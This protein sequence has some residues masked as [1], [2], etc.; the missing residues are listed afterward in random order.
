MP[1]VQPNILRAITDAHG[2]LPYDII[3][4]FI[5][6]QTPGTYATLFNTTPK[7]KQRPL[8]AEQVRILY[9]AGDQGFS[10]TTWDPDSVEADHIPGAIASLVVPKNGEWVCVSIRDETTTKLQGQY[11]VIFRGMIRSVHDKITDAGKKYWCEALSDVTRLNSTN[12][13][14][15]ANFL[16]DP[17]N[18]SPRFDNS[19]GLLT[20]ARLKTVYEIAQDIMNFSSAFGTPE[21][22]QFTDIDWG[23]LDTDPRCGGYIPPTLNFSDTPKGK[24]LEDLLA[25]AGNFTFVYVPA[26]N[27]RGTIRIVELNLAC[28]KCGSEWPIDYAPTTAAAQVMFSNYAFQFRLAEDNTE[29]NTR[30]S[31][32][33]VRLTTGDPIRFYSGNYII[34]ELL[35]GD[36]NSNAIQLENDTPAAQL[37]RALNLEFVNYRFTSLFD[38]AQDNRVPKIYPVGLPLFPDWNIHEDH[39]PAFLE[40]QDA[41]LP[42]SGNIVTDGEMPVTMTPSTYRGLVEY[43]TFTVGDEIC[44]GTPRVRYIN[45]LRTYQ[46]WYASESCPACTPD[47]WPDG[48]PGLG[49]VQKV[50]DNDQNEPE[51]QWYFVDGS[52]NK[53][54]AED[55]DIPGTGQRMTYAVTNY[56]WNPSAFGNPDVGP[57]GLVPWNSTAGTNYYNGTDT[58]NSSYPLPWK[59]LCPYCRGTGMKPEF[60][61]RDISADLFRG[62]NNQINQPGGVT[63]IP[64]D[65]DFTQTGPETF[66]E[67]QTRLSI[68]ESAWLAVEVPLLKPQLPIYQ[69]RNNKFKVLRD[70]TPDDQRN[71][72]PNA[73]LYENTTKRLP[74]LMGVDGS[75]PSAQIVPSNWTCE[76]PYTTVQFGVHA[77]V[78]WALGRVIFTEP[79]V[80]PCR[81]QYTDYVKFDAGAYLIASDGTLTPRFTGRG[82]YFADGNW[83]PTGFWRHARVWMQFFFNRS[84]HYE[85]MFTDRDGNPIDDT[86]FSAPTPDGGTGNYK[87]RTSIHDGRLVIEVQKVWPGANEAGG[88]FF[89]TGNAIFQ[90][91]I[92]DPNARVETSLEDLYAMPLPTL[93]N[94]DPATYEAYKRDVEHLDFP[95]AR[96]FKMEATTPG[97][98]QAEMEGYIS[99]DY[100]TSITR[101]KL[102]SWRMWDDRSR[103]LAKA[104]RELEF[105]NNIMVSGSMR[106]VGISNDLSHGLGY[107]NH[108]DQT[109]A[110][111]VA[112]EY[113]FTEA[114]QVEIQ[115]S[116]EEAR[117]GEFVPKAEDMMNEVRKSQ[118]RQGRVIDALQAIQ[119]ARANQAD[120]QS[121]INEVGSQGIGGI[122]RGQ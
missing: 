100:A 85:Y 64:V 53:T 56:I 32:N 49:L 33:V 101:P 43:Q 75:S 54:M 5:S 76:V 46:A 16:N 108:P 96:L 40:I 55:T 68:Y 17:V 84:L 15:Q 107:V 11:R 86:T 112:I 8:K 3:V 67:A 7:W 69:N 116:R 48:A 79:Q 39:L 103:M 93:V 91:A 42:A 10:F 83:N 122:Y 110:A 45:N 115:L 28:N 114:M 35:D 97:E 98:Q 47:S 14:F 22:F 57:T 23:G 29:W 9:G 106:L 109:I 72:F 27:S 58:A 63:E 59:N 104:L 77:N 26:R 18:P 89:P 44:R 13:T 80:I 60:K 87:A 73:L 41:Q 6:D 38:A 20:V 117:F 4:E 2:I 92:T 51:I 61:I 81:K 24:A 94:A 90:K 65:P 95:R 1:L 66:D 25:R 105:A 30:D 88:T 118:L 113:N 119:N 19:G 36:N 70:L 74:I 37:K 34:P 52:G 99:I 82:Q 31:C 12:V 78:D 121:Q 111:V 120:P 102:F 62:R 21:Y 71:Q 50:Y